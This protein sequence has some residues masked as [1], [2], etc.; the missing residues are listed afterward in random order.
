VTREC[1]APVLDNI[2]SSS[3]YFASPPPPPLAPENIPAASC[4]PAVTQSSV[5]RRLKS[6]ARHASD[7]HHALFGSVERS[8][9][10]RRVAH[11]IWQYCFEV[12]R[13]RDLP[14]LDL[15]MYTENMP[16]K[17]TSGAA[18]SRM[19]NW[20]SLSSPLP[21]VESALCCQLSSLTR[22]FARGLARMRRSRDIPSV[23]NRHTL[24]L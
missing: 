20:N 17:F 6:R 5:K 23:C 16:L 19:Q 24:D 9:S 12:R 3:T 14:G 13:A 15:T 1:V 21:A 7:Q 18:A 8:L 2:S 10:L 11:S 22:S 4:L